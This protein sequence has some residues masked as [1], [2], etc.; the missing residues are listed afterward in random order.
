V[1]VKLQRRLQRLGLQGLG[2]QG[3]GERRRIARAIMDK[4][5]GAGAVRQRLLLPL[6]YIIYQFNLYSFALEAFQASDR[7]EEF[8]DRPS[9]PRQSKSL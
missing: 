8:R 4:L 7:R 6:V 1:K 3:L 5:Q 9:T 2:L